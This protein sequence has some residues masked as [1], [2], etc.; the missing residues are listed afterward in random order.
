MKKEIWKSVGIFKGLDF[1][2]Y[3]VSTFGNI[4]SVD[5][6]VECKN[7]KIQKRKGIELVPYRNKHTGYMQVGLS[8]KGKEHTIPV[9]QLVMNVHNPNPNSEIYTDINHIDEDK[10]NNRLDNLEWTTHKENINHGTARKRQGQKIKNNFI[11]IVQLDFDSNI[12]NVYYK[13]EDF[14]NT[15]FAENEVV[16]IMRER[17]YTYKNYFWI[18]L[19]EYNNF[20]Q[21]ELKEFINEKTHEM[22]LR[23]S[24][25][26][27]VCNKA[28]VQLSKNG[29]YIKEYPSITVAANELGCTKQA[30]HRCLFNPLS[31]CRGYRW[32][33]K[34]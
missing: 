21:A 30:I 15:G 27:N 18:R 19:D 12:I 26:F 5:R 7:G 31:T 17:K 33:Y 10:T 4:R 1:S 20:S 28:I 25:R 6:T 11:P 8:Y 24:G 32:K 16:K 13:V 14:D 3:E 22:M 29:D 34:E 2:Y 9:H 23:M